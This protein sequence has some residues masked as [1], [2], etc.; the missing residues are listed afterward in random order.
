ME[1]VIKFRQKEGHLI[2]P[3]GYIEDG[4]QLGVW[5]N[6]RITQRKNNKGQ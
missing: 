1:E 6:T 4:M 2:V 5:L 3:Q